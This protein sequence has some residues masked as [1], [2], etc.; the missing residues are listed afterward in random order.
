MLHLTVRALSALVLIAVCSSCGPSKRIVKFTSEPELT[1]Q[2]KPLTNFRASSERIT[3]MTWNVENLFDTVDD[4]LKDDDAYVPLASK[5]KNPKH[6]EQCKKKGA[7][8]WIQQCLLWDWTEDVL[9]VKLQHLSEVIRAVNSGRGPDILVLQEV[10]NID[11]LQMLIARFLPD[12][13]YTAHLLENNDYRGIDVGLITRLPLVEPIKLKDLRSRP[14]LSARFEL[15]DKSILNLHGVHLP[16]S[17]TP[18]EKRLKM[19]EKLKTFAEER[20]SEFTIAL[21]DFNFPRDEEQQFQIVEKSLKPHWAVSHLYCKEC[22]GTFHDSF[23]N[24]YSQLDFILLSK[25]FFSPGAAWTMDARSVS[26]FKSLPI[27]LD[28]DDSPADFRFPQL[29]GVSDHWPLLLQIV[30]TEK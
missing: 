28:I 2:P 25:N 21:G 16:I 11:V 26:V 7:Y 23:N 14:A 1:N 9:N 22:T 12:M 18:V 3:I 5:Q 17:P 20:S 27:Q 30:K 24:E 13:G 19:V 8:S 29:T 4:P 10:E 6:E 15:S